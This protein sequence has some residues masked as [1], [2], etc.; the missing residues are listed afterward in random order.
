MSQAFTAA[1]IQ[2]TSGRD[3]A[4]NVETVSAKV[5]AA[6]ASGADFIMTPET[7]DMM[8]PRRKLGFEKA[9]PEATHEALAAFKALA[10]EL[11]I[12][13]LLG[14]LVVRQSEDRLAN[15]SFLIDPKGGIAACYDKIHMFD[16]DVPDGQTYRESKAYR[17]GSKAVLADLPW[18]RLGM[19]VCYDL[20]FP[21]LYRSLAQAGADFLTVPSAFT[22][23]TGQAHWHCLLRARAIETGC[24][25][26]APAQCGEHAEGRETYGHSLIVAP[27]GE[28]LADGGE[29]PGIV[30]ARIEPAKVAEARAMIP[31]LGHDRV[32]S[33][34]IMAAPLREAGE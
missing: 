15:R 26:F 4:A 28:V 32:F 14:S 31:A 19:T 16:V 6:H 23:V 3:P 2:V 20:R 8:E 24:F 9:Q 33:P 25:V 30:T 1:C 7:T 34:P 5:R 12:W 11:E 18:G 22:R 21:A 29:E 13:L 10:A 27:W 17:P